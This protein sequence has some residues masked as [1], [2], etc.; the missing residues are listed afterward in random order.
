MGFRQVHLD[1]HTSEHIPGIGSRFDADD[2]ASTLA[3][4]AVDSVTCFARCHHGYLYYPSKLNPERIHPH[5]ETPDLLPQQIE[6]CHKRGIR[7][8][9]YITVQWDMFT[10]Q[11]HPEWLCLTPD[12]TAMGSRGAFGAGFYETLD[13]FHPGYREFLAK[14]TKEVLQTLDVDGIFFD[15]CGPAASCAPHWVRAMDDAGLDP[16]NDE[17]RG[18]FA[19]KVMNEWM[20]EMTAMIRSINSDCTIFYNSGHVGPRHR[21]STDAFTHYELESLPSGGWGYLH[22]PLAVRYA[23][24]LGKA[25][26]G[27]TGKFHTAWGDFHSYKNDAALEYECFTMISQGAACS[28]GDQLHPTGE[29]DGPTYDLI[30]GVYRSVRE[31]Q[32]WCENA[33]PICDIGVITPEA[34]HAAAGSSFAQ[35][36]GQPTSAMGLTRMFEELKLQFEVLDAEADLSPFKLVVL[37]DRIPID[38]KLKRKLEAYLAGGGRLLAS[39]A[40][41]LEP[42]GER[43]VLDALGVEW[44]GQAE[45]SP[46][47]VVPAKG[48]GASLPDAPHVMYARG[49]KVATTTGETLCDVQRPYFERS[50]RHFCSH[51][52]TPSAGEVAYP[53]I[54]AGNASVYFAHPVFEE[55]YNTAPKW[56]K[57]MVA[58]AIDRL[59]PQR[60]L[61]VEGPSTLHAT[62]MHQPEHDRRIVHLLHYLPERRAA[63]FDVIEEAIPL[64]NLP[65]TVQSDKPITNARLAPQGDPLEVTQVEG[66]GYRVVLPELHGHQMIELS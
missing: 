29:I 19:K 9:I 56:V 32:P 1:F 58:D 61:R 24:N 57:R 66:G 3:D 64:F 31:K 15:I 17:Q 41:G 16:E 49:M 55:Y 50:W 65:V 5:L 44:L 39:Y 42:T 63:K 12:K 4:A 51:Q 30:G 10:A 2:F 13:V 62:L 37:P 59:A 45:Y 27:M 20:A 60:S 35:A 46:D 8:P 53:G 28:V 33:E 43:F 48:I 21:P 18:D 26:V 25:C 47:F 14:H 6:A 52:H 40:S 36:G 23:R 22:F 38:D 7:M 34:F 54:V 11:E